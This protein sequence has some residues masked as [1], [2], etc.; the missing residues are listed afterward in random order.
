MGESWEA[1]VKDIRP[2]IVCLR[3]MDDSLAREGQTGAGHCFLG[4][5]ELSVA[6]CYA[7]HAD[8]MMEEDS[9]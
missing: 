9:C 7:A 5:N 8:D 6:H 1:R 4:G 2:R 3:R